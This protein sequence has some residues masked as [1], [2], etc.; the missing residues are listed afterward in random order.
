MAFARERAA[1]RR[2]SKESGAAPLVAIRR[3]LEEVAAPTSLAALVATRQQAQAEHARRRT[4]R[5]QAGLERF[6]VKQ[7]LRAPD[8]AAWHGWFDGSAVPNPGRMG[9]GA[10]LTGPDGSVREISRTVGDGDSSQAEY[11]ALIALLEAAVELKVGRL[12]VHGDSQVV[13]QDMQD[14]VRIRSTVFMSLRERA[15]VLT[16]QLDHVELV[17]LPRARNSVADGLARQAGSDPSGDQQNDQH[18]HDQAADAA[19]AIT[20]ALAVIQ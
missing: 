6:A 16:R 15:M 19:R 10:V 18:V 17:W 14:R 3:V 12:I 7:A 13:I 8:P 11:L 20:P 4:D 1:A 5:R 2:L 9:V